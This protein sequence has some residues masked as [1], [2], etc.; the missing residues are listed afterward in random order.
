[1]ACRALGRLTARF[2]RLVIAGH[3]LDVWVSARK[4]K[5][6]LPNQK[7]GVLCI[8]EAGPWLPK[9]ETTIRQSQ[10]KHP[11]HDKEMESDN[12]T[13]QRKGRCRQVERMEGKWK[14]RT[15]DTGKE[16]GSYEK[17][18]IRRS[19]SGQARSLLES[20]RM[21]SGVT[22][23]GL[24][25]RMPSANGWLVDG[26]WSGAISSM[27]DLKRTPGDDW[28]CWGLGEVAGSLESAF[29]GSVSRERL[30]VVAVMAGFGGGC[31]KASVAARLAC[32]RRGV[33]SRAAFLPSL[34][35]SSMVTADRPKTAMS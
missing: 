11:R 18:F 30:A 33:T 14:E 9:K 1:M 16:T 22:W 17:M 13:T 6:A 5:K 4:K 10:F 32:G 26:A 7:S 25:R 31:T 8:A 2:S 12:V 19:W 23:P 24:P 28:G 29:A 15:L 27:V 35:S 3:G 20:S 21:S 34:R